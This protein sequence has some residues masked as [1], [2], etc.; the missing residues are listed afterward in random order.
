L[1]TG[2]GDFAL[3]L[4]WPP[5]CPGDET[6]L[7]CKQIVCDGVQTFLQETLCTEQNDDCKVV[8]PCYEVTQAERKLDAPK[9]NLLHRALVATTFSFALTLII[10]CE[11]GDC[12][13]AAA[14]TAAA[15]AAMGPIE[16]I[17]GTITD[18]EMIDGI[19]AAILALDPPPAPGTADYF[20]ALP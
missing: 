8:V 20:P 4:E 11:G 1:A 9:T 3:D 18:E 17:F 15:V 19:K 14:N 16:T 6:E 13:D 5:G 12:S 2:E 10:A 7:E